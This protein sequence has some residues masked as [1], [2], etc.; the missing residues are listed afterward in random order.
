MA[1]RLERLISIKT[2]DIKLNVDP[3][4]ETGP[5]FPLGKGYLL[6][7]LGPLPRGFGWF[8]FVA[9]NNSPRVNPWGSIN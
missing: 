2:K 6:L 1:A 3:H 9:K 7:I 8:L 5:Y 4:Y